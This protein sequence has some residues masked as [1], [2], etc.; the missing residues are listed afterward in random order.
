MCHT[1]SLLA[2][3]LLAL[4]RTASTAP[5]EPSKTTTAK[6]CID[7]EVS[8]PVEAYQWRYD[9]PH[10]DS[11][12]DAMDWTVNVTTHSALN[13][14]ERHNGENKIHIKKTFK[15][16]AKLCVPSHKNTKSSILHIASPG[17]AFDKRL[18]LAKTFIKFSGARPCE[19]MRL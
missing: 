14:T 8:V 6:Q 10:V 13:F 9:Q 19:L 2:V 18:V 12:I 5:A 17:Q 16:S 15:I 3:G 7:L 4:A 11:N 1:V